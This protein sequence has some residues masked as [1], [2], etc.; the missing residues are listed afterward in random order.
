MKGVLIVELCKRDMCRILQVK[1]EG[2]KGIEKRNTLEARLNAHGYTLLDRF[3]RGNSIVYSIEK[4]DQSTKM[5][6]D[7]AK[8]FFK[9]KKTR[10]LC[11]YLRVRFESFE[12]PISKKQ[13]SEI[14][15]VS[16]NTIRNWDDVMINN[17]FMIKSGYYY[18]KTEKF[19]DGEIITT[20]VDKY[21]YISY[22]KNTRSRATYKSMSKKLSV[23]GNI[24]DT[25]DYT[26]SLN[27]VIELLN[28]LSSVKHYKIKKYKLNEN[29]K[30]ILDIVNIFSS[31]YDNSN[32]HKNN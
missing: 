31:Y 28:R 8:V 5:I 19:T 15:G 14:V 1:N 22:W 13:I 26:S 3:K 18:V 29:N 16:M 23:I 7:L 12:K 4:I 2:L 27:E 6:C 10:E 30:V 9:T 24:D 20:E 25:K 11:E 21:N 32:I 17:N